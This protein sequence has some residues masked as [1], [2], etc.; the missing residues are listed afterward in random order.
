MNDSNRIVSQRYIVTGEVAS[1][2]EMKIDS[3]EESD[4]RTSR[5]YPDKELLL[6][7]KRLISSIRWMVNDCLDRGTVMIKWN[8]I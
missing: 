1:I 4:T 6:R 5:L 7:A 3:S 8:L 2:N